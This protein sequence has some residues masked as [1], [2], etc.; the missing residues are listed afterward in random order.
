MNEK[1]FPLILISLNLAASFTYLAKKDMWMF[2]YWLCAA[3]LTT[4]VTFK[5]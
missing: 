4:C 5:N 1:I 2:V 3:T